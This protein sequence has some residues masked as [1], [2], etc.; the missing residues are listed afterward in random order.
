[1]D[2]IEKI[3][4][5]MREVIDAIDSL[6]EYKRKH[7]PATAFFPH[8]IEQELQPHIKLRLHL[9]NDLQEC[10]KLLNKNEVKNENNIR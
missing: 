5:A 10:Y 4:Q 2:I 8:D 7:N 6:I 1:M 3:L 9:S